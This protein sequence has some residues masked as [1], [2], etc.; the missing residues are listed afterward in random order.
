MPPGATPCPPR[1]HPA[2]TPRRAFHHERQ[3]QLCQLLRWTQHSPGVRLQ[4][5]IHCDLY[6]KKGGHRG[7]TSG[8]HPLP[9]R[10]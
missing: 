9:A 4:K 7:C 8:T 5:N 2:V 10:P 6:Q 1:C 3:S